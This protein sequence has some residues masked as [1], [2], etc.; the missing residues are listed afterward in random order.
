MLRPYLI[1]AGL[2]LAAA[3]F[4][5]WEALSLGYYSR[6]GPG[7]GFFPLWLAAGLAVSAVGMAVEAWRQPAQPLPADFLPGRAGLLKIGAIV[8]AVIVTILVF[9]PLGFRL[10]MLTLVGFLLP[11][12]G[13]RS[14]MLTPA[15]ALLGSFGTYALFVN[16]LGVPLPIGF[17][18]I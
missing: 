15:L 14:L 7:P 2:L 8:G 13:Q 3:L 12:L 17:L 16:G 1:T 6:L 11:L 18:G 9:E 4:I 10:T 5:G